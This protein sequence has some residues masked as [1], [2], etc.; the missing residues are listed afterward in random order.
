M[1]LAWQAKVGA[2]AAFAA[3]AVPGRADVIQIESDGARWVTGARATASV[4]ASLHADVARPFDPAAPAETLSSHPFI[5]AQ[6]LDKVTELSSRYS[7]SP[8]LIEALV[9]QESRWQQRAVSRKGAIGLTQL[10]PGTASD[11][12]V[13]PHDPLANL[14]G[15]ARYLRIQLNRFGGDV[16]K[17]LAA[18]NCGPERVARENGI[19]RIRETQ[20]YVAS[21]LR[22]LDQ[23]A[24]AFQE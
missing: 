6:Y 2:I 15:G 16:A 13:N 18:Y 4:P 12:G 1:G 17:A 11:M 21:I 7:L 19:P 22:R 24:H 5:P 14:E 3:L 8:A 9:W 20:N 23:T 10:M